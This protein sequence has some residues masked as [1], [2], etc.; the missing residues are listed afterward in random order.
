MGRTDIIIYK[1]FVGG[2][3]MEQMITRAKQL[4]KEQQVEFYQS[5][6]DYYKSFNRG[7]LIIAT[8]AYRRKRAF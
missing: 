8:V 6:Y 1:Y 5:K 4:S 3:R 2:R 7:V